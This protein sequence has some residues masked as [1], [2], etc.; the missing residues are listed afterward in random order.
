MRALT[1][2][3]MV[4][5]FFQAAAAARAPVLVLGS[6]EASA[7]CG[8]LV[9]ARVRARLSETPCTHD[10]C[11]VVTSMWDLRCLIHLCNNGARAWMNLFPLNVM[12]DAR[13]Q[14]GMCGLSLHGV[15]PILHRARLAPARVEIR[16]L[17]DRIHRKN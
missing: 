12:R 1:F 17:V 5:V 15:C 4:C 2:I 16:M 11:A 7:V 13:G 8:G 14:H 9:N 6:L 3:W 10:P